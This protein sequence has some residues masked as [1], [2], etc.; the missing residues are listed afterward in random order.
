MQ[1]A[2][3]FLRRFEGKLE[4]VVVKG[5]HFTLHEGVEA[6]GRFLRL[7]SIDV[8]AFEEIDD[9]LRMLHLHQMIVIFFLSDGL[10]NLRSTGLFQNLIDFSSRGIALEC[11]LQ[12]PAGVGANLPCLSRLVTVLLSRKSC[13]RR[14]AGHHGMQVLSAKIDS[15]P[16]SHWLGAGL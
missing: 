10:T 4:S 14:Q 1:S 12:L 2:L 5:F 11:P 16:A 8:V 13:D 15:G 7:K 3:S 9:L 6:D